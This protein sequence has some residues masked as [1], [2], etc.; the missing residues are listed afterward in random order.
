MRGIVT[1]SLLL[2]GLLLRVNIRKAPKNNERGRSA[3]RQYAPDAA[4][5]N[6]A[7]NSRMKRVKPTV[8]IY[9]AV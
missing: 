8:K 7:Y 6:Y 1:I 2:F 9:G 5:R 3:P 4:Y